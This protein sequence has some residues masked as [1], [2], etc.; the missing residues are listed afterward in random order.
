MLANRIDKISATKSEQ[1]IREDNVVNLNE[2]A[3][4]IFHN[5]VHDV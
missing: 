4:Y 3:N 1:I 2:N 5:G